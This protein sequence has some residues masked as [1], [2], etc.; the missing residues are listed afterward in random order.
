V[1]NLLPGAGVD[2]IMNLVSS[3]LK[4]ATEWWYRASY[5]LDLHLESGGGSFTL[6]SACCRSVLCG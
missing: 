5:A 6:S 1:P 4:W 2:I 3:I